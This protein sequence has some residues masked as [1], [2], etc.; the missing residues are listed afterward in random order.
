MTG[1]DNAC[2]CVSVHTPSV[3]VPNHHHILPQ[4]WG[5]QT[6]A[7]NLVYLCGNSHAA[8]HQLLNQYVHHFGLPPWEVRVHYNPQ[9]RDL[10]QRAWDQR[11]SDKPSYTLAHP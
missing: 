5:G 10:A 9:V 7:E 3:Y 8:V 1:M 4:S 2:R 11:P 6:V